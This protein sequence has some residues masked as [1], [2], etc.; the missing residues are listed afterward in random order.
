MNIRNTSRTLVLVASLGGVGFQVQT[1]AL[2]QGPEAAAP[3]GAPEAVKGKETDCVQEWADLVERYQP[4]GGQDVRAPN[5]HDSL[6]QIFALIEGV[7]QRVW[8]S[9]HATP[10]D[11]ETVYSRREGEAAGDE[12]SRQR[13]AALVMLE[14]LDRSE[15]D[16]LFAELVGRARAV[17]PPIDSPK[18]AAELEAMGIAE[19]ESVGSRLLGATLP[20]LSKVRNATR[21]NLARMHQAA[22]AGDWNRLVRCFEQILAMARV[23]SHQPSQLD[24]L[25]AMAVASVAMIHVR[26]HITEGRPNDAVLEAI[27]AAMERQLRF[28]PM[29]FYSEG[30]KLMVLDMLSLT[31]KQRGLKLILPVEGEQPDEKG[32]APEPRKPGKATVRQSL[33]TIIEY[34]KLVKKEVALARFERAPLATDRRTF[35]QERI[36]RRVPLLEPLIKTVDMMMNSADQFELERA[37][38]RAFIAVERSQRA[39]GVWPATL[40]DAAKQPQLS[41]MIDPWSSNLPV[42]YLRLDAP[43]AYGRNYLIY[44]VG[45]DG[46]DDRGKEL[47]KAKRLD[48]LNKPLTVGADFVINLPRE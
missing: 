2:A 17:V 8:K 36:V 40:N 45:V 9:V 5:A 28:P 47:E 10:P 35:E 46:E 38:T 39:T 23:V 24:R 26:W 21:I 44:S 42:K 13:A 1:P 25:T 6:V 31:F 18:R 34:Y 32:E 15:F 3:P 16:A 48:A 19:S 4:I 27:T 20:E 33:E 29:E 22:A 41:T 11:F 7:N 12:A 37:G 30:E 43:D 14:E